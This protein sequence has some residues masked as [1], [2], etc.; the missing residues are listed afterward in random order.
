MKT[1]KQYDTYFWILCIIVSIM[2]IG[3]QCVYTVSMNLWVDEVFSIRMLDH[4]YLEMI[5]LTAIDVHPP[6]YYLILKFCTNLICF[7]N[8]NIN[9]IY[10]AKLVSIIPFIIIF[11]LGITKI[12]K[13][14]GKYVSGLFVVSL[15]GMPQ[16]ISYGVEIRMYSWAMLFVTVSYLMAYDFMIDVKNSKAWIAF[17]VFSLMAAY[18]HYFA[19]VAV[20]VIYLALFCWMVFQ[21]RKGLKY[22]L[23]ATMATVLGYLP[24]AFSLLWQIKQVKEDYWI[25]PITRYQIREYVKFLFG[26]NI[27]L[28]VVIIIV[29]LLFIQCIKKRTLSKES[30]YATVGITVLVGTVAIGVIASIILRPV[31]VIRYAIPGLMCLWLGVF[32]ICELLKNKVLKLIIFIGVFAFTI[33]SVRSFVYFENQGKENHESMM[34]FVDILDENVCIIVNEEHIQQVLTAYVQKTCYLWG[35]DFSD[36]TGKVYEEHVSSMKNVSEIEECLQEGKRVYFLDGVNI[37]VT[38]SLVDA[39]DGTNIQYEYVGKYH[40]EC[41]CN[42]YELI[43]EENHS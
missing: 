27:C 23:I 36:L 28:I 25:S 15:I 22:W 16:L 5:Q 2:G 1:R 29:L 3:I 8:N 11:F 14:W 18:T 6:L 12:H 20:A 26:N 24:W 13:Q 43:L 21:N 9:I 30:V 39:F 32:I 37:P 19:C 40:I 17:V 42:I 10:A 7:I 4:S 31:F 38:E 35:A 41:D 34:E 33:N